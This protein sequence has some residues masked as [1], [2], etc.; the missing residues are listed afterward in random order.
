MTWCSRRTLIRGAALVPLAATAADEG[1]R[2]AER[3]FPSHGTYGHRTLS[4]DLHLAYDPAAGT[5]DGR[6]R[7]QAVA[8][9][10]LRQVELDLAGLT[11]HDA[12]IDG[13]VVGPGRKRNKLVLPVRRPIAAGTPFTMEIGYGGR[14]G[15][16]RTPFGQIGW[17]RTG[18]AN[19]GTLVAAQ[20]LG[21][22]SWFPCNDR[23]DDKAEFT[24][25]V[26]VPRGHHAL[27]NG[28][29]V[30][31]S[32]R[33][34]T[35][36]WTYHHPGPM[37]PY[38]AA[39][40]TGRFT[41]D[42]WEARDTSTGRRVT[43]RDAYPTYLSRRARYDL[44]RQPAMFE[45]FTGWFGPYP[46]E[47]YGAV[48]VDAELDQ[49]VENQTASVFGR[50]H[51][52]GARTWETLVAHELVHQWYGNSV[53]LR[54][55]RDIWLNEGFATYGEWLWSEHIGEDSADTIARAAWH[56]LARRPQR[57]RIADPG[58]DRIFDDR[59]Y[60]RGACTLHAL[61]LTLGDDR[62]FALLRGWHHAHRGGSADTAAFIAHAGRYAPTAVEP[63]LHAWL[64]EKQLPPLPPARS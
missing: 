62:F 20:P 28:A 4:Y 44:A 45:V 34:P 56:T 25:R 36:C 61:R 8:D 64:H 47:T 12:R 27:A 15:P 31:R 22:P 32:R 42:T 53:S 60:N 13:A 1:A 39:L 7:I 49:P 11:V 35:E 50:N 55:W 10:P 18:D 63:V 52:D 43:G 57:L 37:A 24:F 9:R 23:P 29:L 54:D 6:A 21:A 40:Y 48:V 14:P 33:G 16:V 51:V 3:Y 58:P 46:F 2:Q 59:V 30:D 26:T 41:H 5:L 19:E 17:D 38:L